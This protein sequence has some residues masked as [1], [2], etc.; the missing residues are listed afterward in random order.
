MDVYSSSA[1][2]T[3]KHTSVEYNYV[4]S[5]DISVCPLCDKFI[6]KVKIRKGSVISIKCPRCKEVVEITI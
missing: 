6:T 3:D 5:P 2:L 1:D 4:K